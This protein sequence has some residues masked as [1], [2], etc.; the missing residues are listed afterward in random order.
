MTIFSFE[1]GLWDSVRLQA[2]AKEAGVSL[3]GLVVSGMSDSAL[4]SHRL[5]YEQ[6]IVVN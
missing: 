2:S 1:R 3:L 6:D 4:E 5:R